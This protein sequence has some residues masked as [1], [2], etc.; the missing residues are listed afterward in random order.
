MSQA[1]WPLASHH[2][3][4]QNPCRAWLLNK[5]CVTTN[6]TSHES[7]ATTPAQWHITGLK[8]R[9]HAFT[10]LSTFDSENFHF[11]LLRSGWYTTTYYAFG[12]WNKRSLKFSTCLN[13]PHQA[14]YNTGENKTCSLQKLYH[15]QQKPVLLL[16]FGMIIRGGF[17]SSIIGYNNVKQATQYPLG[18][19]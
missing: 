18:I 8:K 10:P 13:H 6:L 11:W 19:L 15:N 2:Q 16:Y 7:T 3:A 1:L 14:G 9:E 12:I 5:H 4:E 17:W